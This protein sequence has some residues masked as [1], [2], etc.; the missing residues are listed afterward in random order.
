[1]LEKVSHSER[2]LA[3]SLA[4]RR[5]KQSWRRPPTSRRIRSNR[6]PDNRCPECPSCKSHP[7]WSTRRSG[8]SKLAAKRWSPHIDTDPHHLRGCQSTHRTS[9]LA[10]TGSS[11]LVRTRLQSFCRWHLLSCSCPK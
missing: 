3:A 6:P 1:R 10:D 9:A 2:E 7:W 4:Q 8:R 11:F 5:C